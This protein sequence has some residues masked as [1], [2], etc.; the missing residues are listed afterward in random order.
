MDDI[1]IVHPHPSAIVAALYM[2]R[3]Q[4]CIIHQ[5]RCGHAGTDQDRRSDARASGFDAG[6]IV[7]EICKEIGGSG[8]GKPDLAQGGGPEAGKLQEAFDA[9]IDSIMERDEG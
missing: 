1:K 9:G 5:H 4:D 8:G 7:R 6:A 2:L 3:D